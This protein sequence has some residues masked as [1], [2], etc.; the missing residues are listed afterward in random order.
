MNFNLIIGSFNPRTRFCSSIRECTVSIDALFC[1][2][3]ESLLDQ[4]RAVYNL[5]ELLSIHQFKNNKQNIFNEFR[6]LLEFSSKKV[7]HFPC[8]GQKLTFQWKLFIDGFISAFCL[9]SSI[10]INQ[11]QLLICLNI[12]REGQLEKIW[13][14]SL[15]NRIS[16]SKHTCTPFIRSNVTFW[17]DCGFSGSY[18]KFCLIN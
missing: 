4:K 12:C 14:W 8:I 5:P 1:H 3:F 6:I 2:T 7:F 10:G 9:G 16:I 11:I 17:F 15:A 18:V 13:F